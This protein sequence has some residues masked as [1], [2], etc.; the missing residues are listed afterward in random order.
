PDRSERPQGLSQSAAAGA[1]RRVRTARRRGEL[2]TRRRAAVAALLVAAAGI[3]VG[4]VLLTRGGTRAGQAA[5]T[6]AATTTIRRQDLVETDTETGTL[7]Y[8]DRRTVVDRVSG[9]VTWLPSP[10]AV[11]RPDHTLYRV[12]G[13]PVVLLDGA[14]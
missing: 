13:K 11:I 2:M 8:A 5:S 10:G 9:T 12:D 6:S 1:R 7:G 3:V 14:A 4:V